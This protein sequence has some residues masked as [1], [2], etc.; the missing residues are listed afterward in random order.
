MIYPSFLKQGDTIGISAPSAGVGR[1]L[2]SFDLS[3][4][5]LKK[6]GFNIKE[7]EHVRVN[8]PR[9]GTTKE[10]GD[11]LN[12]LFK[13][14]DVDFVMC[15]AGGDFLN[16]MIPYISF[17][18]LKKH[19]KWIMGASDPT[20]ILYPYTTLCDVATIYGCNAGSYDLRPLPK[21]LKNNLEIIQG[22]LIEQTSFSKYQ[23]D[24]PW[25]V[26]GYVPKTKVSY[27]ATVDD[28]EVKGRC[29]G[30][31]IDGLKDI[32]GTK[33]DGAKKF[34]QKYKDD[35]FIW[36]FDNFALSAENLYRTLIQ[37][38]YAGWFEYTKAIIVGRTLI[39]SS[40][41]GMSYDE[42]LQNIT[43]DIPLIYQADI[44]HTSPSMTMIN[45]AI[46]HLSYHNHKAT[47]K[48]ELR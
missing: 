16:E 48:F 12:Q 25:E 33:F 6:K 41:T 47:L 34:I 19:P 14:K 4:E 26:E 42:A 45:G 13:D 9:G 35:G 18:T 44:G 1:K 3:L 10:R 27:K 46:L 29:I 17:N 32:I 36:Y 20:S 37:M 24:K 7:T 31:C 21:F 38:K 2:D 8:D 28:L 43:E 39:E 30:G 22:N 40:E 5:T 15:A 23:S 11:E